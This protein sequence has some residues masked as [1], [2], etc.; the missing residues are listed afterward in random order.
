MNRTLA[1]YVAGGFGGLAV[2][3]GLFAWFGSFVSL[4]TVD[5]D[6]V[7]TFTASAP[8]MGLLVFILGAIGGIVI[9]AFAYVVG[10]ARDPGAPRFG[11]GW[12]ALVGAVLS[13]SAAF[14]S[15]SLGVTIGGTNTLG[16][17]SMPVT[18]LAV[19]AGVAGLIAGAITAPVVDAL[20]R[21]TYFGSVAAATPVT[22]GEFWGDMAR[23]IG[24]PTIAVAIGAL[25]AIGLAELLLST[26]SATVSVAV[27]AA[28]GALILGG[29][30]L[31]ALRPWDRSE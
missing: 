24:I 11:F 5:M 22:S 15:V 23:A 10:R 16:A 20:A 26:D 3:L 1:P 6:G 19:A 29:T 21:P 7:A 2:A 17:V 14:A 18:S 30:A 13:G 4:G 27:F 25:L 9:A 8:S 12:L 31:F 28:A